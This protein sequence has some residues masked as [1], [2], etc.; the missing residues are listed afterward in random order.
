MTPGA[1]AMAQP[2]KTRPTTKETRNDVGAER[3]RKTREEEKR[4]E[5]EGSGGKCNSL[6]SRSEMTKTQ[7]P[8]Q[9]TKEGG[10]HTRTATGGE[11]REASVSLAGPVGSQ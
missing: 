3:W 11:G 4:V 6:R 1:G 8:S 10:R 7:H 9:I 2:L 5:L